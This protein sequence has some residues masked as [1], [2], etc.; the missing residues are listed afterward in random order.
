MLKMFYAWCMFITTARSSNRANKLNN[1]KYI[2]HFCLACLRLLNKTKYSFQLFH[3]N[4]TY[5]YLTPGTNLVEKHVLV[6]CFFN[7]KQLGWIE[8]RSCLELFA[9][10]SVFWGFFYC[11]C[12]NSQCLSKLWS[13]GIFLQSRRRKSHSLILSNWLLF[14]GRFVLFCSGRNWSI[15][16]G[17]FIG[18]GF[19]RL[20]VII[21]MKIANSGRFLGRKMV[22]LKLAVDSRL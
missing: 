18:G 11:Q 15:G 16:L 20:S 1:S 4:Y 6:L 17:G 12:S 7:F 13:L 19:S 9:L 22:W 14:S 2:M 5:I 21:T 10:R 3:I 8:S